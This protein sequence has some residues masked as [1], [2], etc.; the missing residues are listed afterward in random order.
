MSTHGPTVPVL[1]HHSPP[2]GPGAGVLLLRHGTPSFVTFLSSNPHFHP[3][4]ACRGCSEDR[5]VPLPLRSE[6]WACCSTESPDTG[7]GPSR[8]GWLQEA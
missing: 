5:S 4:A 6:F 7:S 2:R 3:R 1:R 8:S